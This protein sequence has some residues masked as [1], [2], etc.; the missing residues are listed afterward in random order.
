MDFDTF[1]ENHNTE[2]NNTERYNSAT[3]NHFLT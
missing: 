2:S 3:F 1:D